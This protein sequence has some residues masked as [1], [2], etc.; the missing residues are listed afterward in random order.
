MSIFLSGKKISA[1]M[2][3]YNH[4]HLVETTIK[5]ILN[6]NIQGFEFII[7]DDCSTDTTW[8]VL[9]TLATQYPQIRLIRTPYNMG[10]AGNANF[11]ASHCQREYIALLHHDDEYRTDCFQQWLMIMEQYPDTGFVFND[12]EQQGNPHYFSHAS[13]QKN[14]R[15]C[16][17]GRPFFEQELL[18]GF[19]VPMRG[20]A[21]I[22]R[23]CWEQ[24]G[25]MREQFGLL[26]DVDLWMRLARQWS[27]AYVAEPVINVRHERVKNYPTEY[28]HFTWRRL[29]LMHS[30]H[31]TN[32]QEYYGKNYR[33]TAKWWRFRYLVSLE[34]S[35]WLA[36]A[37][38]RK[39]WQM[40]RD[41][42]EVASP[43]EFFP[44]KWL[45][46]I[47]SHSLGHL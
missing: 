46:F 20:T 32:I 29:K 24:L 22:R 41:A 25:G 10:M 40:L 28:A 31:A 7:S 35:K 5:S 18:Q 1:C 44:V 2:L 47:L 42:H 43:Y 19:Y 36:Y 15:P 38:V 11:A 8:D 12:C 33:Y 17:Q 3:V 6:Q 14:F 45:R 16:M 34:N 13:C 4:A 27:V 26:A 9:Q 23:R 37:V 21:M 39:R 30:I